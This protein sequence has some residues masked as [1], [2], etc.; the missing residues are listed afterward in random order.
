MTIFVS[1]NPYPDRQFA[2]FCPSRAWRFSRAENLCLSQMLDTP[3]AFAWAASDS[4][5]GYEANANACFEA[6]ATGH[7]GRYIGMYDKH[8]GGIQVDLPGKNTGSQVV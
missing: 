8:L 3:R 4:L 2:R 6:F 1:L 7:L 5:P